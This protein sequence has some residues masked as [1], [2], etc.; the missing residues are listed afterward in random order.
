M[1]QGGC[2]SIAP[3]SIVTCSIAKLH[4]TLS[5]FFSSSPFF[6]S[7][8]CLLSSHLILLFCLFFLLILF[9]LSSTL[10]SSFFFLLWRLWCYAGASNI[11]IV[12]RP[13]FLLSSCFLVYF[14]SLVFLLYIFP[15]ASLLFPLGI[16]STSGIKEVW[17]D[18]GIDL[19][20]IPALCHSVTQCPTNQI[21]PAFCFHSCKKLGEHITETLADSVSNVKLCG[22]WSQ[23]LAVK[24]M[25]STCA[26][27]CLHYS[28]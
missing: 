23:V 18:A 12:S 24:Y 9:F 6:V 21:A 17:G 2:T 27:V 20:S 28:T 5:S 1:A 26:T 8:F 3:P 4:V 22:G 7:S 10:S 13:I 15:S 19:I 14:L 11:I 16:Y 25:Y